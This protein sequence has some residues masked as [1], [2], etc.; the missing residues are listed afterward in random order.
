MVDYMCDECS[1]G[2]MRPTSQTST[3]DSPQFP[4]ICTAGCGHAIIFERPYPY[5]EYEDTPTGSY[6]G[7]AR[8]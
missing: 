3:L 7:G 6:S 2:V 1:E 5:L 8:H 4:H